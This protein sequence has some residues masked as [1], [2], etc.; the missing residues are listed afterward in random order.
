MNTLLAK[1]SKHWQANITMHA[2][3]NKQSAWEQGNVLRGNA[4]KKEND[5]HI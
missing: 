3:E 4:S 5:M 1:A 2:T